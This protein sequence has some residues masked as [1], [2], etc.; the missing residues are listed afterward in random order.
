MN[1]LRKNVIASVIIFI[2]AV[3]ISVILFKELNLKALA[4]AYCLAASPWGW[5]SLN[6]ITPDKF[7]M[8]PTPM[9]GWII[10]FT[11][12]GLLSAAAGW[13]AMPVHAVTLILER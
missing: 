11:L 4:I 6:K 2:F 10:Y 12:K 13:I 8:S 1:N 5:Q 7:V 9:A 3:G